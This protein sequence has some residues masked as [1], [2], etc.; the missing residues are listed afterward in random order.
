MSESQD[1]WE[2]GSET[3]RRDGIDGCRVK[4]K[5]SPKW[6]N[7]RSLMKVERNGGRA[8]K[9]EEVIYRCDEDGGDR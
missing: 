5:M 3:C 6:V 4:G 7:C 1:G 2:R 9:R 8:R